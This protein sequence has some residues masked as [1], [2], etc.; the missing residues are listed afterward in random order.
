MAEIKEKKSREE[1]LDSL[2]AEINLIKNELIGAIQT[3]IDAGAIGTLN[4]IPLINKLVD[5]VINY[6]L[7]NEEIG[8]YVI[9]HKIHLCFVD[10]ENVLLGNKSPNDSTYKFAK[11]MV[12]NHFADALLTL[13]SK[14]VDRYRQK[15]TSTNP[16]HGEVESLVK[17]T[18]KRTDLV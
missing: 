17:S 18:K 11:T 15:K 6:A 10:I 13:S 1:V 3:N 9:G 4:V 7:D 2:N 14:L 5:T 8:T 12:Q 16:Q